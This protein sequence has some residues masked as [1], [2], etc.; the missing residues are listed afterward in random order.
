VVVAVAAFCCSY[1]FSVT[2]STSNWTASYGVGTGVVGF[3]Q[4]QF[5][6]EDNERPEV[7]IISHEDHVEDESHSQY[8]DFCEVVSSDGAATTPDSVPPSVEKIKRVWAL[9]QEVGAS[10]TPDD[11]NK[12]A[13]WVRYSDEQVQR[14]RTVHTCYNRLVPLLD[15][16]RPARDETET[17]RHRQDQASAGVV[18][19]AAAAAAATTTSGRGEVSTGMR[20][21]CPSSSGAG[22]EAATSGQSSSAS[23]GPE[24]SRFLNYMDD[25]VFAAAS[26]PGPGR[27][28]PIEPLY[29]EDIWF[30][31]DSLQRQMYLA[32]LCQLNPELVASQIS[33]K[34]QQS[35]KDFLYTHHF[36]QPSKDDNPASARTINVRYTE[37]NLGK[38]NQDALRDR[39]LKPTMQQEQQD[40]RRTTYVVNFAYAWHN[41]IH[42]PRL[43]K[44]AQDFVQN[45]TKSQGSADTG[46]TATFQKDFYVVEAT[47]SLWASSNGQ[48]VQECN[49]SR[50]QCECVPL[51]EERIIGNNGQKRDLFA[52]TFQSGVIN[53]REAFEK[54]VGV[55]RGGPGKNGYKPP[56]LIFLD[57]YPRLFHQESDASL[58]YVTE[59][60]TCVPYCLPQNWKNDVVVPEL[61]K[62]GAN[63]YNSS[64]NN[65]WIVPVWHQL[66]ARNQMHARYLH[67]D[68]EHLS[69]SSVI[70]MN[71]QLIRTMLRRRRQHQMKASSSSS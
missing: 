25:V 39:L 60:T 3:L 34:K 45:Y 61:L 54:R 10:S 30:V 43:R 31:G 17:L 56:N 9:Q 32:F 23:A 48:F 11:G 69:L 1:L 2:K 52:N 24:T 44:T 4:G 35:S 57:V 51:N 38:G 21:D 55:G 19:G 40:R 26:E 62:F 29:Y 47:D 41:T 33:H 18:V 8:D 15:M 66:V 70:M 63:D 37:Y 59:N 67:G 68:C 71:E 49:P 22:N 65:V 14:Y 20:L 53:V 6:E 13:K 7:S 16:N 12:K 5:G 42:A 28:P 36:Q 27:T 58:S 64:T 46:D 50:Y